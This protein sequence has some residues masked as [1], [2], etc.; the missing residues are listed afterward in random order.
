MRLSPTVG[1]RLPLYAT[2]RS[3]ADLLADP[4]RFTIRS[5][6]SSDCGRIF[7]DASGRSRWCGLATCGTRPRP[8][9]QPY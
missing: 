2:A 7:L 6:P 3:A 4:K 5:C 1:L 8:T 9:A